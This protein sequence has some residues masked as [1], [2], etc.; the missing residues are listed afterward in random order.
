MP[1]SGPVRRLADGSLEL[2][3]VG[4]LT[5]DSFPDGTNAA[6]GSVLHATRAAARARVSVGVVTVA[7]P[8]REARAG[9]RELA[10]I[11]ELEVE[12]A[13]QTLRFG[14]EEV[15]GRRRL[16][17]E[18]AVR[19]RPDPSRLRRMQARALLLAPVGAELDGTALAMLDEAIEARV[20][21]ASLQGWL[22]RR[23][24]GGLVAPLDIGDVSRD[25]LARLRNC[26]AVVVSHE[27]LGR[28]ES[29]PIAAA[30]LS[31]RHALPGPGVIVTWGGAGY[32]RAEA[33]DRDPFVVQRR[34]A[35][36]GVPTVGAGD[37]FA[38]IV[39]IHLARGAS[40]SAAARAADRSVERWLARTPGAQPGAACE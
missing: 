15:G 25:V 19:L 32:V 26:D 33:G 9:L 24:D 13:V 31:V 38:A 7:G 21:V 20:R 27:D 14:H 6:G 8:E 36:R 35:I 29:E 37:A 18:G 1:T 39:A 5:I 17:V 11:A 10:G 34:F 2:L 30:A 12:I 22:R 40:L 3:V 28:S 16:T 23:S 4:G